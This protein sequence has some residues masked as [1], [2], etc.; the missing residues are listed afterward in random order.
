MLA[1]IFIPQFTLASTEHI[2]HYPGELNKHQP[3]ISIFLQGT[4]K[5]CDIVRFFY[6]SFW[7]GSDRHSSLSL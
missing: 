3:N 7:T 6:C 2:G 1:K 5:A 4:D